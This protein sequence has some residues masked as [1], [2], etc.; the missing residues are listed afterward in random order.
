MQDEWDPQH[1]NEHEHDSTT[2]P[3]LVSSCLAGWLRGKTQAQTDTTTIPEAPVVAGFAGVDAL[4]PRMINVLDPME[5]QQTGANAVEDILEFVPGVDVR[6][7]GALAFK[8]T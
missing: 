2:T 1:S 6:S 8:R 3:L 5:V 7:R 4:S